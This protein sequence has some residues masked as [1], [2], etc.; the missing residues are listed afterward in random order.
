[1]HC[2]SNYGEMDDPEARVWA[3]PGGTE[4]T[5]GETSHW[6]IYQNLTGNYID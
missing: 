4:N 5:L 6:M 2:Y 3:V 1:M